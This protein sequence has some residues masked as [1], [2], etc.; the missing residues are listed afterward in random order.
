MS[1]FK[2]P[3]I[4]SSN[5]TGFDVLGNNRIPENNSPGNLDYDYGDQGEPYPSWTP[6][7][8]VPISKKHIKGIFSHLVAVFGFQEDSAKN[9]YDY[10]MRMLDSR[11]SRM[12]PYNALRT[13]HGD[14]IG[15]PSAN[16]R[17]WYFAAQIDLDDAFGW[18]SVKKDGLSRSDG[19]SLP[20]LEK[21][22][23]QWYKNMLRFSAV[24]YVT[25]VALYLLC[26]G[27]ANNVRF[28][29]EC[30]CFIFKCCN[31]YYYAIE[32]SL[33]PTEDRKM[34]LDHI[35]TPLYKTYLSHC[36]EVVEGTMKRKDKDHSSIIGYDD[37]N[38]LFWYRK[39]LGNIMLQDKT[40]LMSLRKESRYLA[41]SEVNWDKAFHKT[42]YER[43]T[44]LHL[45]VD[46]NRVFII[47][48]TVFWCYT[49]F[50]ATPLYTPRYSI[51]R[52]NKP[53]SQTILT[54][55]SLGGGSAVLIS[56]MGLICEC[57]FVPRKSPIAVPV[58][59][60]AVWLIFLAI[61]DIGPTAFFFFN[62]WFN[63]SEKL[64]LAISSVQFA[65]SILSVLYLVF[66]TP[67]KQFGA[68]L[69]ARKEVVSKAFTSNF[70][71][72]ID[73]DK[74]A[75]NLLW[76]IIFASKFLESYFFLTLSLKEPIRELAVMKVN[77][78]AGDRWLGTWLCEKQPTI[79]LIIMIILDFILFFLDTYLWYV[80]W[81][82]FFSV[83]RSF[84]IGSSIWTPWRNIFS[85][86]PKRIYSKL[87]VTTNNNKVNHKIEVSKV[88]NSII[89]SMYR[90]HFLSIEQ[91][92]RLLYEQVISLD[93]KE[94]VLR[95]PTFFVSQEDDSLKSSL[96]HQYSEAQ[97]RITFFAQ[98]LSTPMPDIKEVKTMPS[99]TVLVPHYSETILLLLKEII[100]EEDRY[101]HVTM[102]EYLKQL[103]PLEWVNFVRDTK[104]MAEESLCLSSATTESN[105]SSSD[106]FEDV[107]YYSVGFKV[108]TPE[109]VTRTRI[110]ASLRSQTLYRTVTGFMNYTR[111]I[112]LMYDF[113]AGTEAP[114]S[115]LN[116]KRL[117]LIN[118]MAARKFRLIVSMQRY[119]FFNSEEKESAE[120]L[121][122]TYP[123]LQ[124]A[125]IDEEINPETKE[126]TYFSALID[127]T[128]SVLENG[129]RQ[130]KYK[131]RLSGYPILGDGKSDNQNHALIFTRGEYI[132]LIDANQDNY[133]EEC[134]KIR[135]VLAEFEELIIPDPYSAEA[136]K[137]TVDNPVAIIGTRE[138]I[139]SEN[140]G[141]LGDVAAAKE[142]TFGTLFARTLAQIGGKLHY[143]HPDFLNAVF[144]T[145]RGGVSKA[146]KGLHLNE[147]IYAGM[148]AIIRGG[149]I[150]HCEY[151]QCGKGRDL[152]FSS[153]SNF[154]TKIGA[155]MG[156]QLLSREYYYLGTKLPLDR[157]LSFYYAHAGFHLNNV[158]II[159]SIQLFLL[160][161][162]NIAALTNDSVV[163][164]Y[165]R[166]QP[167]TNPRRPLNCLN[168]VPIY[169]W[170]ERCIISIFLVLMISF[171]PLAVQELT[172]RG[173][174]KCL[175]R[176]GKHFV[177]L[178]PLFEVFVCKIYATS[179]T[180][181][182]ALGGAQY[183]AT[184][185]NFATKR[186]AFLNLYARF[187]NEALN[188]GA[189]LILLVIYI[190][191]SWWKYSFIYFWITVIG[192]L[193]C[194]YLFNPNQFSVNDFFIDYKRYL[195]WLFS[196]NRKQG[197]ESWITYTR[198]NR[199]RITG[200]K[201]KFY[202][203]ED[204][205]KKTGE[206]KPRWI[207]ILL[208]HVL[209]ELHICVPICCAY[210][211][212]NS[213]AE[214]R[215]TLPSYGLLR[216]LVVTIGPIVVNIF[217][218]LV[219]FV[220]SAVLGPI[221][222]LLFKG[223][224]TF[225]ASFVHLIGI[226]NHSA[227]VLLLCILQNFDTQRCL[228][229]VIAMILLQRTILRFIMAITLTRE[230]KHNKANFSW[231]SG[232]WATSGL[233][234]LILTQP[235]REFICKITELTYF[236]SDLLVGHAIFYIQIPLLLSPLANTWHSLMLL[237]A[238][239]GSQVRRKILS[240][241]EQR[242]QTR[243]VVTYLFVFIF[244]FAVIFSLL[245]L[246]IIFI[247]A[248]KIDV[249]DYLPEFLEL[250]RQPLSES[251]Q[252]TGYRGNIKN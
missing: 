169:L 37:M 34:F 79:I 26:W 102:L 116:E 53:P 76:F 81:N 237:W 74:V 151:M 163:C 117:C 50:N 13:L 27:E 144:V 174:Y 141:I 108:A 210:L 121:L 236:T 12:G 61:V 220:I 162:V 218:L 223:F 94:V 172:E 247:R 35:I 195:G 73:I 154:I 124:I 167:I 199:S 242:R 188:T 55:M 14:Y 137:A 104:M 168:L 241:K 224:P 233:G 194:P 211:F 208:L 209:S 75:S 129:E 89:I 128:C 21:S 221:F 203:G 216:L 63:L 140:V 161:G 206:T 84:Y 130:P 251:S 228:L 232:K 182:L 150:K 85:R 119:K 225:I 126:T 22:I 28:M 62:S 4:N 234:W 153:I 60:R 6:D 11:A 145:T 20:S 231:W 120:F 240:R 31:D 229:G 215:N 227:F 165:E 146:Q 198:I 78:C 59:R 80:I 49:A 113:E 93:Q 248:L 71:Q 7:D 246:P 192:L 19:G 158:C 30:L 33:I 164:Y 51:S 178:S 8:Q 45:L 68:S 56:L 15:G 252:R 148:N 39:G 86:L 160:V 82:T 54:I 249:S 65:M 122:R 202:Y 17:K 190:S 115:P 219:S 1:A 139:F 123:E 244:V 214:S 135:G 107:P 109:Y 114:S 23:E 131:V 250:L 16:F 183:I 69:S 196:G 44:W 155:G 147:D 111:A 238:K 98:S 171:V 186:E 3:Y 181:D 230:L 24:D 176:L 138:Y 46:F 5:W 212:A 9:I 88:W 222:C 142:Q 64:E 125:Y 200:T 245:I 103:H 41:L 207:N 40:P 18:D 83:F 10:F 105:G 217:I 29:P 149:R 90:E 204:V 87:L 52:D 32:G 173:A 58:L 152:G 179:L 187:A 201:R 197:D 77:R 48:L 235:L 177:S 191:I 42:Y 175:T 156:E 67:A 170:L 193:I 118:Q 143:G 70:A 134:L 185:R 110:W 205:I 243:T 127:G 100:K 92:Q 189:I 38:Q 226:L 132:Q 96:F 25:Q 112:K 36:Y 159:S 99:F 213:Q 95:E 239:P 91:V 133:L 184:G 180:G 157:F 72:L 57:F 166:H 2:T 106:K 66:V 101:T 97:R 43:R 47:H 136:R